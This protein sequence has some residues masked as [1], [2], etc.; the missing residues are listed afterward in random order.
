MS[1]EPVTVRRFEVTGDRVVAVDQELSLT[2]SEYVSQLES[3][4]DGL[5]VE[6]AE[7]ERQRDL[8]K[9]RTRTHKRKAR[10]LRARAE[11]AEQQLAERGDHKDRNWRVCGGH[12]IFWRAGGE[13]A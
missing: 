6:L 11:K 10:R 7:V 5:L 4:R 12:T 1:D 2:A 8:W 9:A 13:W 3:E